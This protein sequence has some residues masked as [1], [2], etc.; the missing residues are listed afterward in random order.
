VLQKTDKIVA[1][2]SDVD[3]ACTDYQVVLKFLQAEY[4]YPSFSIFASLLDFNTIDHRIPKHLEYRF[5]SLGME[6]IGIL[7]AEGGQDILGPRTDSGGSGHV[8]KQP[9]SGICTSVDLQLMTLV[10]SLQQL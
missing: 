1:E 7:A 9:P 5:E 4:I 10:P 8:S 2:Y 6:I 3:V